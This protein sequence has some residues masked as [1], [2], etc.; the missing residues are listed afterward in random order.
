M[1]APCAGA[2]Q[3]KPVQPAKASPRRNTGATLRTS[4]PHAVCTACDQVRS[5]LRHN[6][7]QAWA[8]QSQ[9]D[10][11]QQPRHTAVGALTSMERVEPA[12]MVVHVVCPDER[13]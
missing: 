10:C 11:S 1:V 8:P 13:L 6:G 2:G 4:E 3:W 12:T 5:L 7:A 9:N